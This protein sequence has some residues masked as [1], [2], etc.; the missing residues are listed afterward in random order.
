MTLTEI[1]TFIKRHASLIFI[2]AG[3]LLLSYVGIEYGQMVFGQR[4]LQR[5]WAEQQNHAGPQKTAAVDEGLMRLS[6]PK[7]DLAAVVVEGTSSHELNLGP[8]HMKDTPAPGQIGNSVI[9]AHRDTFFRHIYELQKG[10]EILV[11]RSGR[12]YRYAVISKHIVKPTDLSVVAASADARLTLITCYPTYFIGPA[13][14]RLVVT[15]QL[16][17]DGTLT[18]T[19]PEAPSVQKASQRS[20]SH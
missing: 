8:G 12:T 13:P 2:L 3:A 4:R 19:S 11:Q 6:I 16:V 14:E 17:D 20:V 7:I 5:T 18:Q 10:D 1:H 15:S 9:T